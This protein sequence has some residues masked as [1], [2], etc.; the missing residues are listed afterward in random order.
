METILMARNPTYEELKERIEELG[1]EA[2]K[3]RHAEETL[4]E[5][6]EFNAAL[7]NNAPHPILVINPDTSIRYVNPAL[8]E[9]TGFTF[10]EL[11]GQRA[12]YPWWTEGTLHRNQKDFEDAIHKGARRVEELFQKKNGERFWVEI[13]STPVK[14]NTE[15]RYYLT[16]W[17]DINDRKHAEE[18]L[19]ESEDKYRDLVER[20][21][22][23][24]IILQDTIVQY[25]N[26]RASEMM[27]YTP[28]ESIGTLFPQYVHPDDIET[29]VDRYNRRLSGEDVPQIYEL[30]L[31]HKDGRR[32]P[33]EINGGVI[34][35]KGK[36]ADMVIVR[37]ITERK[38]AEKSL[39]MERAERAFI[40][41]TFGAYV[42][43]EVVT[44][45]LESPEGVN[46]GGEIRE[47]TI[48]VSDLREFTPLTESMESSQVVGII[49]RYLEKMTAIIMRYG[50]TIDEFIGDGI[51]VFF[52][53][54]IPFPDHPK[55]AVAC[56][57]EM[58]A[59][60]DEFNK[61]SIRLG[62]PELQMG[63]GI[64]CGELI[65]GNIG[66]KKRKKY[67]GVGSPINVAFRVESQTSGGEILI[68]PSVQTRLA[69]N[70]QID[71][72]REVNLKGFDAPMTLF[73]VAGMRG[74]GILNKASGSYPAVSGTRRGEV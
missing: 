31:V 51:L 2:K 61:E 12:P 11:I 56:A 3:Y 45:I 69:E 25:V 10:Q 20:A 22:D 68:T 18:A 29:A 64:N 32:V 52:G 62:I 60:M 47:I 13:T 8:E 50:G 74:S 27:G 55:R 6:E 42:S 23:A 70:L 24:I 35:Y 36:P 7:L 59:S 67:G 19:L 33:V 14:S 4:Q 15:F 54:P 73:R 30:S 37:D 26:P 38:L 9:M 57:L 40:R 41:E 17:V 53:A 58:Q 44:K 63:I 65:I 28:E 46:L 1:T 66:S 48:L 39:E 43:E 49:N 5:S 16:N 34:N 72:T 71:A 21:N